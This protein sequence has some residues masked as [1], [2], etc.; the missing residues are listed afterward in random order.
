MEHDKI[1]TGYY[2]DSDGACVTGNKEIQAYVNL[3]KQPEVLK[4]KYNAEYKNYFGQTKKM[5]FQIAI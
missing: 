1:L 2:V 5:I 3:L 4:T